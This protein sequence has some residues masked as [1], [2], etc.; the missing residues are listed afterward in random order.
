HDLAAEHPDKLT[1]LQALWFS[2]AAEY[3]G[4]PLA[5]L[6]LL[7]TLTRSRPYLSGG[8]SSHT[9]YPDAAAVGLGAGG[10]IR[11]RSFSVLAGVT[12]QDA[13]ADGVL[14][15]QGGAHGGHVL[16]IQDGRLHYVYNFLGEHEQ[17][18]SSSGAVPLGHHIF[19]LR[20]T[21][22]GTVPNSHTPLGEAVLYIDDTPVARLADMQTQP[23]TF[24]LAGATISVGRNAGSAVSSRYRAPFRFTGG[25]IAR[26]TVEVSGTPHEDLHRRLALAFARD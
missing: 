4:L 7:E 14:F 20:Y 24:G 1:E 12:V 2:E 6:S 13:G 9:Y 5:D 19:G 18:L 16:F 25:I 21:R 17:L 26:V 8:R 11:G 3:H 22:A 23:G 10:E 15:K